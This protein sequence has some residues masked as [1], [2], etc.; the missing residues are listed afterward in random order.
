M[1]DEACVLS[2]KA[3]RRRLS[4]MGAKWL[5]CTTHLIACGRHSRLHRSE[6]QPSRPSREKREAVQSS[7]SLDT[8]GVIPLGVADC[9]R[10]EEA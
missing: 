8:A 1:N 4:S 3:V 6:M 9:L 7:A 5:H 10:Q 2:R